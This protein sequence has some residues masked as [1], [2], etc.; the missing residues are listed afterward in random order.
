MHIDPILI[1]SHIFKSPKGVYDISPV[2]AQPSLVRQITDTFVQRYIDIRFSHIAAIDAKGFL[3]AAA[4]AYSLAKPL[5]LIR[6]P[7]LLAGNIS[8][9]PHPE[10]PLE[11]STDALS[12]GDKV[13]LFDDILASGDTLATA[14]ELITR[15]GAKVIEMAVLVDFP[16]LGGSSRFQR[17]NLPIYSLCAL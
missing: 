5:I 6:K 10:K 16:D 4:V 9:Q 14:Q 7:G 2:F 12:E 13:V 15:L 3:I 1:Q 8:T 11:I 17:Q